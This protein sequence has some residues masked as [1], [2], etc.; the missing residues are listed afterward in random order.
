MTGYVLRGFR[1][2]ILLPIVGAAFVGI[3]LLQLIMAGTGLG[4]AIGNAVLVGIVLQLGYAAGLGARALTVSMQG[5][6][7]RK[8]LPRRSPLLDR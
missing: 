1:V 2:W 6:G 3:L 7:L 8:A 5:R 4:A